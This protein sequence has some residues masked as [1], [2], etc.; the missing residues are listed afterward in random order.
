MYEPCVND[1]VIWNDLV[2][3]WG[4][5]KDT[6]YLTIE[7]SVVPKSNQSYR[8]CKIHANNR[9]LVLCYKND[10]NKLQYVK[11]RDSIYDD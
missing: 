3:G 1:Y 11:S 9:V 4:Y 6:E 10:W 2:Q 8:D 5:Y 7:I